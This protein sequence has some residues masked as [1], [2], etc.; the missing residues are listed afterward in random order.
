MSLV[1]RTTTEEH[2][3]SARERALWTIKILNRLEE[4]LG[5]YDGIEFLKKKH[6]ST[7]FDMG[8]RMVY[9]LSLQSKFF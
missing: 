6:K 1:G 9:E 7:K 5:A 4:A 8:F 3:Q 2:F